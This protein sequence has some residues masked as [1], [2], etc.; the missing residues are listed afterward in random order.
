MLAELDELEPAVTVVGCGHRLLKLV[1]L[2]DC[3]VV[4]PHKGQLGGI[5][6]RARETDGN[7][8]ALQLAAP[9]GK[10]ARLLHW[11]NDERRVDAAGRR[12]WRPRHRNGPQAQ[13]A[14]RFQHDA[15]AFDRPATAE[16]KA[17]GAHVGQTPALELVLRPAFGHA[18]ARRI[19][20]ARPDPVGQI[21]HG[22]HHFA[23]VHGFIGNPRHHRQ[24]R[25]SQCWGGN[26]GKQ[27]GKK[28]GLW[29]AHRAISRSGNSGV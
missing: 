1:E 22:F 28:L 6:R 10:I 14:R 16:I 24:I 9:F 19:G 25:R 27:Q 17:F 12:A 26:A 23:V 15:G 13:A 29:G 20:H 7:N 3:L 11:C 18:H 8:L 4:H 21:G 2:T 5:G